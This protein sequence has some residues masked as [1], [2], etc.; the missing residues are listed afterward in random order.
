MTGW[1]RWIVV[2]DSDHQAFTDIP[3]MGPP[4]GI[5]PAKCSAAIA[6]PYVAAFLD[7]HRKARR[8]PLLDKPSTQ[9]PEV[10]LCP[11]KCGQS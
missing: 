2:T 3:L 6:R 11:E 8:Q 10:K 5:K 9:Y 4:L 7:Q 1:K